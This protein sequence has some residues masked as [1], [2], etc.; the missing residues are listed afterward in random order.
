MTT[1]TSRDRRRE[2][3]PLRSTMS[4]AMVAASLMIIARLERILSTR[5]RLLTRRAWTFRITA[6]LDPTSHHT[7]LIRK[8]FFFVVL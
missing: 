3:L 7:P 4:L 1:S 8:F 2:E 6:R 5:L